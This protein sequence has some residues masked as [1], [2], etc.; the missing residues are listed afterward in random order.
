MHAPLAMGV[1]RV[2]ADGFLYGGLIW[3]L[4]L[5]GLRVGVATAITAL[6]LLGLSVA[7][8]WQP[9]PPGE[10]TDA[11]VALAIGGVVFLLQDGTASSPSPAA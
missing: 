4:T 7:Q 3:L 10:I 9:G 2:F 5:G 1:R 6:M 11:L 8:T